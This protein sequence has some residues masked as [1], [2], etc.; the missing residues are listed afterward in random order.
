LNSL[1]LER[2]IRVEIIEV[3][4]A[5]VVDSATVGELGLGT[6]RTAKFTMNC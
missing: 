6:D 2:L 3:V 5:E 1:L 4:G